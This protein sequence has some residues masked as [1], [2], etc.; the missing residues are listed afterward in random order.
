M[1]TG[2]L[3]RSAIGLAIALGLIIQ[4]MAISLDHHRFFFER[5]LRPHFWQDQWFYFEHSQLGARIRELL[6]VIRDGVPA[7]ADQFSPTPR[8][9]VTYCPFGP[10]DHRLGTEWVRRF[11]VFSLPRPWPLWSGHVDTAQRPIQL[12]LMLKAVGVLLGT[13]FTLTILGVRR[14]TADGHRQ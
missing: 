1:A 12:P 6:V 14:A 7:Q 10:L 11:R 8:P 3:P 4:L 9:H 5:D 13:G 2:T